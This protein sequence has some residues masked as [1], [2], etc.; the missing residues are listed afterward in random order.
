MYRPDVI[1]NIYCC[2]SDRNYPTVPGYT[3]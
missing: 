1:W 2:T 3:I